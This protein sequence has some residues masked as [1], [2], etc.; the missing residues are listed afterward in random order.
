MVAYQLYHKPGPSKDP[1]PH[2]ISA[3]PRPLPWKKILLGAGLLMLLIIATGAGVF[4]HYYLH[5]ARI[6]DARLEGKVF[7]NP[8][9]ILAAPSDL[10]CG[11]TAKVR[12]TAALLREIGYTEGQNVLGIGS[13]TLTATG[14]DVRPGPQSFFRNGQMAEGPARLEFK[15][16]RLVSITAL[17][18]MADLKTYWLEPAPITTLFGSS[19]AKRHLVRY[20]DLPQ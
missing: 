17:D 11:Q 8:A 5:F 20:Q 16:D 1:A 2:P 3:C 7:G 4:I 18:T 6:I 9:V 13:F 15:N 12:D 19:R 10:H 14:L